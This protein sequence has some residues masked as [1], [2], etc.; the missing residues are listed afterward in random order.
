MADWEEGGIQ[1]GQERAFNL[2]LPW[3]ILRDGFTDLTCDSLPFGKPQIFR[4]AILFDITHPE[5]ADIEPAHFLLG[6]SAAR[7]GTVS[8]CLQR[9]NLVERNEINGLM[10]SMNRAEIFDKC[11]FHNHGMLRVPS[12]GKTWKY[13][14]VKKAEACKFLC[15]LFRS[16][17][18]PLQIQE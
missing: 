12:D 4:L 8:L 17:L 6:V 18:Q 3:E 15:A 5:R 7:D 10:Q 14:R 11:R 1:C 9:K 13:L 16:Q 2:E